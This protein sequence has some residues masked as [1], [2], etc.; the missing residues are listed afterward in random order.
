PLRDLLMQ[1]ALEDV[2]R[3]RWSNRI[4]EEWIRNL[5]ANRPDLSRDQLERT[6]RQMESHVIDCLVTDYE[7]IIETLE[8]PDPNDR[9]VRGATT[10]RFVRHRWRRW[11]WGKPTGGSAPLY[12]RLPCVPPLAAELPADAL[13]KTLTNYLRTFPTP[14]KKRI[15]T[16]NL[17]G[18]YSTC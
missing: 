10:E 18:H 17:F 15:K 4:Q 7:S 2:F 1:L 5:L 12:P 11:L 14:P 3:A 9:H 16:G 6:R 13:R 8:L